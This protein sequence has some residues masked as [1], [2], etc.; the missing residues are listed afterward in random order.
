[1]TPNLNVAKKK[2]VRKHIL[3]QA[4]DLYLHPLTDRAIVANLKNRFSAL[5]I[6]HARELF[7][8]LQQKGLVTLRKTWSAHSIQVTTKGIDLLDGAIKV[9][10]IEASCREFAK[11]EYKKEIRR[12]ILAYC[13]SFQTFFNED[14]EILEE[15]RDSGFLNLLL[16]EIRFHIWYLGQN[17]LLE[18]K[19]FSLGGD[20]VF[21]ARLTAKGVDVVE[22]SSSEAWGGEDAD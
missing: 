19:S 4:S 16:E 12:G 17:E 11:L 5:T 21:M 20:Q 1:M 18:I 14:T 8:Y 10:G 13:Y 2:V 9:R 22:N 3:Q 6:E 15:F 7:D